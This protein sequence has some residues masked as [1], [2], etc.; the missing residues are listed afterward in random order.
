MNENRKTTW[1]T[2]REGVTRLGVDP[3]F[4]EETMGDWVGLELQP[5]GAG[6][7]Q[8][9]TF[10]SII[11]SS[12]SYDL[13]APFGFEI[14]KINDEAVAD[15]RIVRQSPAFAGWLIEVRVRDKSAA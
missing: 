5:V 2:S 13:K 11:T 3:G 10:G 12:H 1:S 6:L 4:A 7:R 14:V 9:D 8:G 15:P